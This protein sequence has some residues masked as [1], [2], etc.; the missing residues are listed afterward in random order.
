VKNYAYDAQNRVLTE[1][2]GNGNDLLSYVYFPSS[3]TVTDALNRSTVYAY[4][5]VQGLS[6]VTRITDPAGG[7]T[8][9]TYDAN[10]N[11]ATQTDPLGRVTHYTY[12][13]NGNVTTT[14]DPASGV[15]HAAYN[16]TFNLPTAIT[17]PLNHT[18]NMTYDGVGNLTQI[19]DPTSALTHKT[20]NGIGH[21]LQNQDPLNHV[22]AYAYQSDN[23]SLASVTDPLNHTTLMS[24][25]GL[26][27]VTLNT[28]P[29]GKQT[30]YAYDTASD[31]T[32]VT[33]AMGNVTHYTYDPGR[34]QKLLKTVTDANGHATTFGYDDLGRLTSVTNALGQTKTSQY[35]AKGN[36]TQT[37]NARGQ[38]ITYTYDNL[39]RLTRKTLPEGQINYTY[40]AAG[41]ITHITHYNGSAISNTY[42]ALNRVT[43]VIQTLPNGYSATIGYS[44]DAAGNRTGMT[45]PWGSFSYQYDA[46]NRLTRITN[47][48]SKVFSFAYDAA[49]RRTSLSY[50]NGI[51]TSYTYDNAGQVLSI[52]AKRTSDNVVVSSQAYTY[53]AAGNR[54]SMADNEGTHSYSY[55][56][57][58]RLTQAVHPAGT[59]LPVQTETFSYDGVGNRLAD[60]QIG[61]YTY[62]NANR[63]TQN[64][65]FTYTYDADGNL[66]GKTDLVSSEH[67]ALNFDSEN[68]LTGANTGSA[69]WTYRNDAIGRRIEKSSG[70]FSGQALRY[71]YDGMNIL[72]EIDDVNNLVRIYSNARTTDELLMLRMSNGNEYLYHQDALNSIDALSDSSGNLVENYSYSGYGRTELRNAVGTH[73]ATSTIGN[74][75]MFGAHESDIETQLFAN[76]QRSYDPLIG[77][78]TQEEPRRRDGPNLYWYA[79]NNPIIYLDQSGAASG[80]RIGKFIVRIEELYGKRHAHIEGALRSNRHIETQI[81]TNGELREGAT[82]AVPNDKQLRN[83]LREM[84][85]DLHAIAIFNVLGFAADSYEIMNAPENSFIGVDIF[86]NPVVITPQDPEWST[87]YAESGG[88]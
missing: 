87:I 46:D 81:Y 34:S 4:T 88:T 85:F 82:C 69:I 32:Q 86:G 59:V 64:S 12:D 73:L 24:T 67:S 45:T 72:A 54:T 39:D 68:A 21:V 5:K 80:K 56:D 48:Q 23:G 6:K 10:L 11:V 27:Q 1:D 50:P 7:V 13:A 31:L 84:G 76:R 28:D 61:G 22:T 36:L 63:L 47:P 20:Y 33:D 60:S 74:T 40:D 77:R 62:D 44:Y 16:T 35:D 38:T 66:S 14:Q 25:D 26:G 42:D 57:L 52:I 29:S 41:N 79:K 2:D 15:T 83:F 53:D 78:F 65:S 51:V 9:F 30:Q 19:Q 8:A 55:D 43:Q 17:D 70:T 58:H 37:T 71:I 75:R 49:G 18:T 3:T